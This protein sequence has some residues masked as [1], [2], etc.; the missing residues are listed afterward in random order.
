MFRAFLEKH[1]PN[2]SRPQEDVLRVLMQWRDNTARA[3]DE[4]KGYVLP[5][6]M[7]LLIAREIPVSPSKLFECCNPVPALV[8]RDAKHLIE[9]IQK[10]AQHGVPC[11]PTQCVTHSSGS[12]RTSPVPC[13][14]FAPPSAPLS[15]S[16]VRGPNSS[17]SPVLGTEQL[18]QV[19]GWVEQ[20]GTD[21]SLPG[22]VPVPAAQ[23]PQNTHT[24]PSRLAPIFNTEQLR[25]QLMAE[26]S[27]SQYIPRSIVSSSEGGS[28]LY[29]SLAQ[30]SAQSTPTADNKID[31]SK[32]FTNVQGDNPAARVSASFFS[33]SPS[34]PPT[35]KGRLFEDSPS[36]APTPMEGTPHPHAKLPMAPP[37]RKGTKEGTHTTPP[38]EQ[39]PR[40]LNEIY[41]LSKQNKKRN[42]DKK[43]LKEDSVTDPSPAF[44]MAPQGAGAGD[45]VKE[46]GEDDEANPQYAKDPIEFMR[47]IGWV[48][49]SESV[50]QMMEAVSQDGGGGTAG[51]KADGPAPP[52]APTPTAPFPSA[53]H[54]PQPHRPAQGNG[55]RGQQPAP[56]P[57]F[58][59]K[60]FHHTSASGFVPYDYT[61]AQ[62]PFGGRK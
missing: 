36:P 14:G 57:K 25:A 5:A 62:A 13:D 38:D 24:H 22:S 42:K 35:S 61:Q 40:S 8:R 53:A 23:T 3:E 29:S 49:D 59:K 1:N 56:P 20:P 4:S 34:P 31:F 9:V 55:G 2:L 12:P 16:N 11:T 27:N 15:A 43:K 58:P 45:D 32:L 44:A 47:D 30:S 17:Q 18:Y 37:L 48:T 54:A 41:S 19:A 46:E 6:A 28:A 21:T 33:T 51:A 39:V 26:T 60:N 52:P 50:R 7:I 10:A